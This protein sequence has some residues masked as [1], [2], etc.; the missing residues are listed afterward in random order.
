M[1]GR[2]E[3]F[4]GEMPLKLRRNQIAVTY[5]NKFTGGSPIQQEGP[6]NQHGTKER[7]E[8]MFQMVRGKEIKD[9]DRE[10]K[11]TFLSFCGYSTTLSL[12]ITKSRDQIILA[13]N[14]DIYRSVKT[15]RNRQHFPEFEIKRQD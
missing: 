9:K 2:H 8:E 11:L 12:D 4:K 15:S 3:N 6:E 10:Y 13:N 14:I 5:W 1:L 7:Q